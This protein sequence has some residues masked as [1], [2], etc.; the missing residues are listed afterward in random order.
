MVGQ[1]LGIHD[2]LVAG[3][4]VRIV[5]G[6][7]QDRLLPV[8]QFGVAIHEREGA[9]EVVVVGREVHEQAGR[10][11]VGLD[12]G[13]F[14]WIRRTWVSSVPDRALD[15]CVPPAPFGRFRTDTGA[16]ARQGGWTSGVSACWMEFGGTSSGTPTNAAVKIASA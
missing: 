12:D 1:P 9:G 6:R 15:A 8:V 11:G 5:H 7:L 10:G 13:R 14:R 3:W 16:C 4:P 2:G